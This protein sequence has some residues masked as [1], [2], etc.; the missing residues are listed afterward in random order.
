MMWQ[1]KEE[2]NRQ[3]EEMNYYLALEIGRNVLLK[4]YEPGIHTKRDVRE[5]IHS[6]AFS[7]TYKFLKLSKLPFSEQYKEYCIAV[8]NSNE[9]DDYLF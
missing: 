3:G 9:W 1:S 7:N 4:E 6:F 2:T 5:W 8:N